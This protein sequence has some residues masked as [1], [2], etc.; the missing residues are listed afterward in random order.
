MT[1]D[2]N[3]LRLSPRIRSRL[4]ALRWRIRAY[5]WLEGLSLIAIWLGLMFWIGF[6]ID[7]IPVVL[8]FYLPTLLGLDEMSRFERILL[9]SVMGGVSFWILYR[10]VLRRA[11]VRLADHSMAILLERQFQQEHDSLVTAVEMSEAPDHAADFN[12]DM[13]SHTSQ[14]AAV[15]L[16]D[17]QMR[18]VFRHFPLW[19]NILG[20]ILVACSIVVFGLFQRDALATVS[21]RLYGLSDN[22]YER[23]ARI[24]VYEIEVDRTIW[25]EEKAG[26]A[27]AKTDDS[28]TQTYVKR[29]MP[30]RKKF[31]NR[32]VKV[33]RG[34]SPRLLVRADLNYEV[35]PESCK[36]HYR[37]ADGYSDVAPMERS[38]SSDDKNYRYF[39][40]RNQPLRGIR[41]DVRFDV[42]GG[43]HRLA[44]YSVQVVDAPAIVSA[45]LYC[46][47]PAYTELVPQ[48]ID[49][50]P[51]LKLPMGTRIKIE[52]TANKSLGRVQVYDPASARMTLFEREQLD[53]DVFRHEIERLDG[54]LG[55]EISFED[56]DGVDSDEPY[57]LNIS[58]VED[59]PPDVKVTLRGIGTSITADARLPMSGM[60][61]DD[62][63][64]AHA[65]FEL[66]MG[67][68]PVPYRFPVDL[69]ADGGV[70]A[71]V[72]LREARGREKDPLTIKPGEKVIL[73]IRA[74]DKCDLGDGPNVGSSERHQLDVVLPEVLLARLDAREIGQRQRFE[75]IIEEM[76]K[77]RGDLVRVEVDLT[78]GDETP[79]GE[80]P[81]D[82]SEGDASDAG[83][84]PDD[85]P[86]DD[87]TARDRARSLRLLMIQR[88]V[89]Q[90]DKSA[91]EMAG[92]AATFEDIREELINN[93][94]DTQERKIR[95][96]EQIAD[97]IKEIAGPLC[98]E[99]ANRLAVLEK[100]LE[101]PGGPQ[102]AADGVAQIDRVLLEMEN[103][104]AQMLDLESYNELIE[105]VRE[106]IKEQ[107]ELR[108]DT[109]K[110]HKRKVM[111]DLF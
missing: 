74:S 16:E 65:R 85:Q 111:G 49:F 53:G 42:I 87:M 100:E 32:T 71:A 83:T 36:L 35:Q 82:A 39:F 17:A 94:V 72:D 27:D 64:V 40:F 92:V 37:T 4:G 31:V 103:V 68:D 13:L 66:Q 57:C 90:A 93:R 76:T 23:R 14:A 75:Q 10:W 67:D 84:E 86:L 48:E 8:G 3:T 77:T 45:R 24:E 107:D 81:E 55:I 20:A 96:K 2:S 44:G 102:A 105:I 34:S 29:R 33:A 41:S 43:D 28:Q 22:L 11:F 30:K 21:S 104:L 26:G 91:Q 79:A 19:R 63:G 6:A 69:A 73:A 89:L 109:K 47:R 95:L 61:G 59:L 52:A 62:Y 78:S 7:Y 98:T 88:A 108:D 70:D 58:A 25:M 12:A 60:I 97:P 101:K 9:L 15:Q 38:R 80:E 18:H 46:E 56:E 50:A 99:L 106:L 54:D 110:E 5:V 51:G 1:A